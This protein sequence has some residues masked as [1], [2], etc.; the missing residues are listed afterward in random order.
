MNT[1]AILAEVVRQ[2]VFN[3]YILC[4][5]HHNVAELHHLV[6]NQPMKGS[7]DFQD[8]I[9]YFEW[10]W[11][12]YMPNLLV[13][14]S[15]VRCMCVASQGENVKRQVPGTDKAIR[16]G[17]SKIF[18]RYQM[19]S[20][21]MKQKQTIM[22]NEDKFTCFCMHSVL[23]LSAPTGTDKSVPENPLLFIYIIYTLS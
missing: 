11:K 20:H 22:V 3:R 12:D 15:S 8:L 9:D 7:S 16:V 23:H 1:D 13:D 4:E 19:R 2:P 18:L 17:T 21:I 14:W 10:T 6:C 5:K